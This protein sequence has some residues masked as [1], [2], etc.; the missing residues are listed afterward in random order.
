MTFFHRCFSRFLNCTN[1]TKLRKTLHIIIIKATSASAI[2]TIISI[3]ISIYIDHILT[4]HNWNNILSK[5]GCSVI[6]MQSQLFLKI[7]TSDQDSYKEALTWKKWNIVTSGDSIPKGINIRLFNPNLIRSK[8]NSKCFPGATS[9]DVIH[10]IKPTLQNPENQFETAIL[11]TS[12]NDLL[13]RGS[14][15][16]VV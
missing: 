5:K 11:Q 9:N 10:Y 13:R 16:D 3:S 1:G 14:N 6:Y 7:P 2:T 4:H 12:I 8:A 15:I